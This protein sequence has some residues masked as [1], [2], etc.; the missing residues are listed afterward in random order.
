DLTD[1]AF[2]AGGIAAG[3]LVGLL[4]VKIGSIPLTLGGGGGVLVAGRTCGWLRARRPTL[5]AMPPAA[6]QT[7]SDLGL[8]GFVA[9]IGLTNGPAALTAILTHGP[10]L[11]TMGMA[12]TLVP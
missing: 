2:L 12:V 1:I 6:Q 3:L 5:G 8:G 4:G 7:L 9:A 11:L 10:L